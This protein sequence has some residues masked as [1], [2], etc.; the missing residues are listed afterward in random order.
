MKTILITGGCGF[1]G[2]NFIRYAL[3]NHSDWNIVNLDKLTYAGNPENLASVRNHP[4]YRF[5]RGDICDHELVDSILRGYGIEGIINFAA[6]TH[7][8]RSILN[9]TAFAETNIFGTLVLL[10][11]VLK[12][13]INRFIQISTDEVYGDLGESGSFT[14]TSPLRPNSP[15]A[16]TKASADLLVRSYI[17]T[18]AIPAIITRSSNVY[19]PY[20][21]PEKLIPLMIIRTLQNRKLPLYGDGSNIR[22]WLHV[23]DTCRAIDAVYTSGKVGEIYNIGSGEE[24]SN[25]D[26]VK[27]IVSYLGKNDD[28]IEFVKDRPGH[29]RR[30]SVD[31]TKLHLDTSWKPTLSLDEG[32]KETIEWYRENSSWWLP[33]LRNGYKENYARMYGKEYEI[34]E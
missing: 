15:Y 3:E 32:L 19:G 24:M 33:I 16:A 12:H 1:I 34:D 5:L 10:N 25:I 22:E 23:N 18:H 14:E 21:F 20:Q 30:Y 27:Q 28:I 4:R 7:V 2:S 31:W 11:G 29:D 17:H 9:S 26:L 13:G 8:D 6:E